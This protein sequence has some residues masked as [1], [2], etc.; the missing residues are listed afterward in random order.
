MGMK[1]CPLRLC[2]IA[3]TCSMA[4]ISSSLSDVADGDS[5]MTAIGFDGLVGSLPR[6]QTV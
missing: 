1:N 6:K 5:C 3:P 2:L 4:Y